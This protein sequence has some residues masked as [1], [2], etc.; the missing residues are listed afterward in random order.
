MFAFAAPDSVVAVVS[1]TTPAAPHSTPATRGCT[2]MLD[3]DPHLSATEK[4]LC[5]TLP[6]PK[7]LQVGSHLYTP[8]HE[9]V[10]KDIDIYNTSDAVNATENENDRQDAELTRI[11]E[12]S[13]WLAANGRALHNN[14]VLVPMSTPP[15]PSPRYS[16]VLLPFPHHC[17]PISPLYSPD[18]GLGEEIDE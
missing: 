7:S 8:S 11:A 4:E 1:T 10:L 16:P 18:M 6:L 13:A 17:S 14:G 15:P 9:A 2:N 3:K 12:R 5:K